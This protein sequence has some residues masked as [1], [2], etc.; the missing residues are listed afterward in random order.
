MQRVLRTIS[1]IIQP[2]RTSDGTSIFRFALFLFSQE[3]EIYSSL[4]TRWWS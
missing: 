1:R 2:I 3:T 4:N